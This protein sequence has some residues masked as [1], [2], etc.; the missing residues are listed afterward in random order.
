M[1]DVPPEFNGTL[2]GRL[3]H[4]TKASRFWIKWLKWLG[5]FRY[6]TGLWNYSSPLCPIPSLLNPIHTL[7]HSPSFISVSPKP[8][9]INLFQAWVIFTLCYR[10]SASN[11]SFPE[12]TRLILLS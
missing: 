6:D 3:T 2:K 9:V 1:N 5:H 10:L 11:V 7:S 12:V 4:S 8:K